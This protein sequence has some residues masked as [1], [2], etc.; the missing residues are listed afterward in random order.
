MIL[1]LEE[2][3]IQTFDDAKLDRPLAYIFKYNAARIN[4]LQNKGAGAYWCINPQIDPE[5]RSI[6]NTKEF[7]F[8]GLDCD[9]AKQK[10]N[11]SS[12]ELALGKIELFNKLTALPIPPSGI[13]ESRNGLHPYWNFTDAESL[14]TVERRNA[15][16][17]Y[18]QKILKNFSLLT[19]ITSEGDNLCRVLRLPGTKHLKN[20]RE[21]FEI[22]EIYPEGVPTTYKEFNQLYGVPEKATQSVQGLGRNVD[23]LRFNQLAGENGWDVYFGIGESEQRSFRGTMRSGR[24]DLL[25]AIAMSVHNK[26]N[27]TEEANHCIKWINDQA[28]EP[29]KDIRKFLTRKSEWVQAHPNNSVPNQET[30]TPRK[31]HELIPQ[32][33]D[34]WEL[35]KRA[36]T[37][38][39]PELDGMI[40]GFIPK[41][42]YTLTGKTNA[43]KTSFACNLAYRLALQ[44]KKVLYLALEP[45][46][47]ILDILATIA[48]KKKYSDLTEEDLAT[49]PANIDVFGNEVR[50][51][52]QLKSAL[53]VSSRYDLVIVDHIGYFV[54]GSADDSS[55]VQL[56]SELVQSLARLT[57]DIGNSI[58]LIAHLNREGS[59][60]TNP[61]IYDIKWSSAFEQDSTDVWILN[62]PDD[63]YIQDKPSNEGLLIVG[64]SK[65]GRTGTVKL[66]FTDQS[67]YITTQLEEYKISLEV[68]AKEFEKELDNFV[69]QQPL[70]ESPTITPNSSIRIDN[71]TPEFSKALEKCSTCGTEIIQKDTIPTCPKC[72]PERVAVMKS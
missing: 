17:E 33:L 46:T 1:P 70:P 44:G 31:I 20:P 26:I 10:D 69:P 21:P 12:D 55:Y 38:G 50:E 13:I 8:L 35:E 19:G 34:E 7:A 36:G 18:Y 22:K 29:M 28:T 40:K 63:P 14:E 54:K 58:L 43:G 41:H 68:P 53:A 3:T 65:A 37:T 32:R 57:K 47:A 30:P 25:N 60:K 51:F 67:G 49:I 59:K 16:N 2:L 27:N 15:L 71:P 72:H 11:R 62:R 48:T 66:K 56:Q 6:E 45:D 5:N 42:L 9:L 4:N 52:E 61:S 64:K 39:Y 24:D 23:T